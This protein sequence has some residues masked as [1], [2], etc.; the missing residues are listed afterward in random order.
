LPERAL[1]ATPTLSLPIPG[2]LAR[3]A[4]KRVGIVGLT[5]SAAYTAFEALFY[6]TRAQ[7]VSG[8]MPYFK[9]SAAIGVLTGLFIFWISRR[10]EDKPWRVVQLGLIFEVFASLQISLAET[11]IPF[12]QSLLLRGHSSLAFWISTFALVAPAP[13]GQALV[14][15]LLSAAMAP[16]GIAINIWLRGNPVPPPEVWAIWSAAP[17]LMAIFCT[18]IAR[19]IYRMGQELEQVKNLGSYQLLEPVGQGGMGEVW[20][21]KHR[22]LAREAA[23]KLIGPKGKDAAETRRRF[24]REAQAIARLESPHT[25]S[26]FD[27]GVTPEGQL[28]FAMELI[29]GMNLDQLVKRFGPLPSPRVRHIWL[30]VLRS[31]EEAHSAGLV[32]RDIKP[33]NILLARMGLEHDWVKVV[34]FGLVK[35]VAEEGATQITLDQQTLGTPA[36]MAPELASGDEEKIDGR[37]DL[38]STAC[39]AYW[40]LTGRNVFSGPTG[41]AILLKHL[42]EA[43]EPPSKVTELPIDAE[44]ERLLLWCLEK[45]PEARP[46]GAKALREALEAVPLR[47]QWGSRHAEDW[48]KTNLP[49]LA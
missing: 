38:Y 20:K 4:A 49:A 12:E 48:W 13:Y 45:S 7:A 29:R 8:M 28:Y 21:A 3:V 17:F 32:H 19:W 1:S 35:M 44:L 15:A 47:D 23:V 26:I 33:S 41:M 42:N 40:L 36:F 34:D 2:D 46:A 11:A 43:P 16:A 24:E 22:Y 37:V 30:G 10:W 25:V 5:Y 18:W 39:V 14:A 6:L 27:F 31:L 9:F